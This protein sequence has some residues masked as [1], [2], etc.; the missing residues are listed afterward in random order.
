MELLF[1]YIQHGL[2]V[3][4]S[5]SVTQII[6]DSTVSASKEGRNVQFVRLSMIHRR[7]SSPTKRHPYRGLYRENI[8]RHT[9]NFVIF[10]PPW[11]REV[12]PLMQS[13][14]H[15]LPLKGHLFPCGRS[16]KKI[17]VK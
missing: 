13:T 11:P 15:P 16:P 12:G 14:L 6:I 5:C 1:N 17:V 4:L 7:H 2:T 8:F 3:P 10:D 9:A